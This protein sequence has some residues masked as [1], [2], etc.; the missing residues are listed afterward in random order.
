MDCTH[1]SKESKCAQ[2]NTRL[3]HLRIE[4]SLDGNGYD[5][6]K[7]RQA[8]YK[9]LDAYALERAPK[10]VDDKPGE[11]VHTDQVFAFVDIRAQQSDN[12]QKVG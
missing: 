4:A 6:A 8:S 2:K 3:S 12:Y 5:Q 1:N 11:V 10:E 9:L 7:V